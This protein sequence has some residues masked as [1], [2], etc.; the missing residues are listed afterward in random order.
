MTDSSV[1]LLILGASGDLAARLLMPGLGKLLTAEPER[2]VQLI[3]AGSDDLS[4]DDWKKRV[5]T[6]FE[7]VDASGTAVEAILKDSVYLKADVTNGD[8]LRKLLAACDG[9]PAL[10]FALPP[11]VTEKACAQLR[12]E[13]LPKGSI[14]AMEK[15]FGHDEASAHA[16]NERLLELVPE[17]NIHRVDH[18]LGRSTVLNLLGLRFANRIFEPLLSNEHVESIDIV[19]DEELSLENR[20]RYYDH[21]GAFVDMIQSHLLQVMT[22][23]TMEA[24]ATLSALDIRD[25]KALVLRA[26]HLWQ[27]DPAAASHR[28]RYT[29]GEI[30]GRKLP[31]YV[32][33][34]GVDPANDTETLAELIVEV[35][36]WRWSGVP[37]RL[38]S[39]KAVGKRR[40]EM[41]VTFKPAQHLPDGFSGTENPDRL[42]LGIVPD[43]MALEINVNGPGEPF[44]IDRADV[45]VDF[46]AGALTAYAEVLSGVLSDD[47]TLS[48]RG[49]S[50]EQCWR[51]V[52]PVIDAW[53]AGTVP[54]EEYAAGSAG[55]EGWPA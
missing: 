18:F 45:C 50:A 28:A 44:E 52:Q 13:D 55:P 49:D 10:Y 19:Y 51:I 22:V 23:L 20:A 53:K 26:T 24:P 4:A 40:Q 25:Q 33:E 32:D 15:P 34:E 47:P 16:L 11:A 39:G 14:L 1:T 2:K 9:K 42:R 38:R 48:I 37:I 5:T 17:D 8:D 3:G 43:N 6:S 31:S 21:A 36:N 46:G 41:L 35:R 54:L 12:K 29:A 7:S 30:D 27:D